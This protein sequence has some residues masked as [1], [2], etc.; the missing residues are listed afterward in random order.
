MLNP[1]IS[2]KTSSNN[3]YLVA[4]EE[5]VAGEVIWELGPSDKILPL[6]DEIKN[7]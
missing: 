3:I 6:T 1:K 5:I 7:Q 2:K 4:M